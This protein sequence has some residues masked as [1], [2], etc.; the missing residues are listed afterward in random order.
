MKRKNMPSMK[1]HVNNAQLYLNDTVIGEIADHATVYSWLSAHTQE[2]IKQ[3]INRHVHIAD[4]LKECNHPPLPQIKHTIAICSGKG[5]VGKSTCAVQLA[6][7]LQAAGAKVALLDADIYGPSIGTFFPHHT[8]KANEKSW[9]AVKKDGFQLMSMSYLVDDQQAMIWRGPMATKA[10]L[11]LVYQTAWEPCDFL[12]IDMPP[13]TG[14]IQLTMSQKLPVNAAVVV[15]QPHVLAHSDVARAAYMLE[16]TN[17]PILGI[18]T[19]GSQLSCP[20]CNKDIQPF[21]NNPGNSTLNSLGQFN[22]SILAQNGQPDPAF[23][24]VSDQV[25]LAYQQLPNR[26]KH[27]IQIPITQGDKP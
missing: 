11:Q 1:I 2:K 16:Q 27:R 8:L 24:H 12:I 25:M 5:G 22:W 26:R 17:I 18:L 15:T 14:D 20:H 10:L 21:G 9:P 23:S 4:Q 6:Y 3:K 7:Q 19:N 13:G